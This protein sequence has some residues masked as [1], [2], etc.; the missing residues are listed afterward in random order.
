M[1]AVWITITVLTVTTFLIR[2]A[3]PLTLG[4]RALPERAI[5]VVDLLAPA[6]LT[7]IIVTVTLAEGA[8]IQVDES[9][10][11]VAAAAVILVRNPQA[12]L[13]AITVAAVVTA[14]LRALL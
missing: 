13:P 2:A 1:S 3:G 9:L 10:A 8:K 4:G 14:G 7:A 12:L 11:G 6:L 5:G